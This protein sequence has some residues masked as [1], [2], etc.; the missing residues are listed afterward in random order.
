MAAALSCVLG[1]PGSP[2]PRHPER[3]AAVVMV[4][5][6]LSSGP[7]LRFAVLLPPGEWPPVPL[8]VGTLV[9]FVFF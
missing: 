7:F 2:T 8:G 9:L 5:A 4:V 6:E 1:S 3:T